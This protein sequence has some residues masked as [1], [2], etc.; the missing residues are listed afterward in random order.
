MIHLG[1]APDVKFGAQLG[2][3]VSLE[4]WQ[5]TTIF[6]AEPTGASTLTL[7]LSLP[8]GAEMTIGWGDGNSSTVT[9]P[10]T[11]QDYT[12]AYAGAGT[13][14]VT[15]DGD[16]T[17]LT[18]LVVSTVSVDGTLNQI[19]PLTALLNYRC[20]NI[21]TISG[22]LSDLPASL[23]YFYCQGS[24]TIS[25]ALSDLPASL[26]DFRC[27]GSNTIS[28]DLS[29][30][31]ASLVDFRCQ[32]SNTISGDLSDLPVSLVDFRCYGFN[33][34][35]DYTTKTWTTIPAD[36]IH[37]PVAPG[38]LST[39]EID[40]LL[41]DLDADLVWTSGTITLT[42]TNAARSA[43]SDAAVTNLQ[44]EGVTVTTN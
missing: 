10:V 6:D 31:S 1:D 9:G 42:G 39:S 13:F 44:S 16:Y 23:V 24:N 8:A 4:T 27:T 2:S 7:N 40:Q 14:P 22:N 12:N 38:G 26:I 11:D 30:L 28:G 15:F 17:E 34:I 5:G 32:G 35:S 29:D 20:Q 33:T 21:N 19:R 43:A 3:G 41:I 25:G 37:I 18:R 36:L